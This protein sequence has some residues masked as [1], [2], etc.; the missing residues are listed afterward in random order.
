MV[1]YEFFRGL[2]TLAV[3][4]FAGDAIPFGP[5]RFHQVAPV[6]ICAVALCGLAQRLLVHSGLLLRLLAPHITAK[7][8]VD[9][10]DDAWL[11]TPPLPPAD[12]PLPSHRR[13]TA[14]ELL[15]IVF[16]NGL[17]VIGSM[18]AWLFGSPCLGLCTFCFEIA[19]EVCDAYSLG[20]A[21]LEPETLLHHLVAPIC[22]F[23]SMSTK[24]DVRVLCHLSICIDASGA[25]LGFS[26][27]LLQYAHVSAG[28]VYRRLLYIYVVLRVVL[29]FIDTGIIVQDC[30]V[31]N[32]GFLRIKTYGD[33]S[34]PM[35]QHDD[36]MQLYFW[37]MAVMDAFNAYFCWVIWVRA[38]KSGAS[39]VHLQ[40]EWQ[41]EEQGV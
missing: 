32:G 25:I 28:M 30:L 12:K 2:L 22:I 18:L 34:M 16:H 26:K 21:R 35:L 31:A 15:F 5:W 7:L 1:V 14:S 4:I 10:R 27:F 37:A 3:P 41:V 23:C 6:L 40:R 33:A 39:L 36:W 17:V 11:P 19:Y 29:P 13:R 8:Q 9:L 24:I 20:L 38:G